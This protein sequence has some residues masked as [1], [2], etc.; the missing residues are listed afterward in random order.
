MI[1]G[2]EPA[3]IL[4]LVGAVIALAISFGLDWSTEQVGAVMAATSAFLG[5]ITRSVVSPSK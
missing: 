4:G 2:R 1:F 3:L 5:L